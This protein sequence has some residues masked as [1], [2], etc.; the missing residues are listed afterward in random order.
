MNQHLTL[1]DRIYGCMIGGAVGDAMGFPTEGMHYKV[2]RERYGRVEAPRTRENTEGWD[3]PVNGPVYTDDTVMKHM[4]C[5]AIIDAGGRPGIH[6]VADVWRRTITNHNQW[7][8][9]LNTRVVASKLQWNP[10]LDLREVGRDSIPCNDAAM[11]IGPIGIINAGDPDRA[12]AEAWDISS[13]WQNGY[14]RECAAAMAACH[15]E[16]L[17]PDASIGSIIETARRISPALRPHL[18][19]AMELV[20]ASEGAEDFTQSYYETAL[21]FPNEDFWTGQNPDPNWSF[22]ADPLE[23]CTEALA[24]L[25]LS[26]G[27]GQAAITG[28]INFGRD[29]DTIAG[30]AGAFCGALGGPEVIP[31]EWRDQI[32][33]ANPEPDIEALSN[34][35]HDLT[36]SNLRSV[37]DSAQDVLAS[38]E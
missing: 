22:G 8:W 19:R 23:V 30:I 18:D 35:L 29:C 2:I 26:G 7:I 11:I 4:V 12:A 28:A 33:Q 24:F 5:Q 6:H 16:A 3:P 27:D 36:L 13:L 14:S 15:A 32:Q 34:T 9:W 25:A 20:Q 1:R 10:L 38:A 31:S 17:R 37:R 21:V